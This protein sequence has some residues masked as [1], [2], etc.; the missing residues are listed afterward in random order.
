MFQFVEVVRVH[1]QELSLLDLDYGGFDNIH[2][3]NKKYIYM[4]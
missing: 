3:V 1:P 2:S 4:K